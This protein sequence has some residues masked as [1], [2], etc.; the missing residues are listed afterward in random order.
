MG[1]YV[2]AGV[3]SDA[4]ILKTKGPTIF[5]DK[6]RCEFVRHCKFIDEI[7]PKAPYTPTFDTLKEV[8]CDYFAHGDDPCFRC[9]IYSSRGILQRFSCS[10]LAKVC[11]SVSCV[12]L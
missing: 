2:C 9:N 6:E 10:S 12:F 3:N 11:V 4:D 8:N 5:N 1:D 7:L